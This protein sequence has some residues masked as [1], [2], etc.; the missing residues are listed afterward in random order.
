MS[1]A[2]PIAGARLLAG[3]GR[4][5]SSPST[6]W[7]AV[8]AALALAGCESKKVA[9]AAT[10]GTSTPAASAP[11]APAAG[12]ASA[13]AASAAAPSS[14]SSP[15]PPASPVAPTAGSAAAA[16][17][18]APAAP[19]AVVPAAA[20]GSDDDVDLPDRALEEAHEP[21]WE[22]DEEHPALSAAERA[23][24]ER[25]LAAVLGTKATLQHPIAVQVKDKPREVFALYE[26][27]ADTGCAG[28]PSE[29]ERALNP[30]CKSHGIAHLTFEGD[31]LAAVA[32]PLDTGGCD[33]RVRHWFV[34]NIGGDAAH[35]DALLEVVAS[36]VALRRKA[37]KREQSAWSRAQRLFVWEK[38]EDNEAGLAKPTFSAEIDQW[39]DAPWRGRE[40]PVLDSVLLQ[41][42][43]EVTRFV[44][45]L[46]CYDPWTAEACN[47]DLRKRSISQY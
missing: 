4:R 26:R 30:R 32:M 22:E 1:A 19:S 14:A 33:L 11:T 6:R 16:P 12:A 24:A 15:P 29:E 10:T 28:C 37:K 7:L 39:T 2:A 27:D 17:V 21:R 20:A 34:A 41:R 23:A 47:A 43:D 25:A 31:A 18:P 35:V 3:A 36:K 8:G 5:A 46:P 42:R 40:R 9:P 44:I 45:L 38:P 13:P